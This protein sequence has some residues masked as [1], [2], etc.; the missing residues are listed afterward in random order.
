MNGRATIQDV[1]NLAGVSVATVSR[2]LRGRPNVAQETRARVIEAADRLG[3]EAHT[4]ASSLAS[5][6]TSIVGLVAP[7]FGVWYT[8]QVIAGVERVLSAGGY[9]LLIY[10]VD[11]L[12]SRKRFLD[13]ARI[14]QTRVDGLVL[15]DFFPTKEELERLAASQPKMV[16]I[17][18]HLEPF[19]SY[20][21][22]NVAAAQTAVQHLID[23]GH[24]KVALLG[25]G[26]IPVHE[27]RV[28]RDRRDG[29]L[30]AM[31]AAG[32]P[33]RED[34]VV[35]GLLSVEGGV[36]AM[37][38]MLAMEDRP[39]GLF[40]MSD[41]MAMG[42]IGRARHAGYS[43]PGDLSV[44]GFDDHDLAAAFGLTTMRQPVEELGE[45]AARVLLDSLDGD[46]VDPGNHLLTA[47][48]VVRKTTGP[49]RP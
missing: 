10:T 36:A 19:S 9:D 4:A 41:E 40:C 24:T 37:E 42:V 13:R 18:E 22:D 27:S 5:G 2:A 1:A 32:L 21:I 49:P 45:L 34:L 46:A 48:L 35:P 29:Y 43:V 28:L 25:S 8:G 15:V 26:Q 23:L 47:E 17:G 38:H 11:S 30:V 20:A 44:V 16:V 39:T 3:Y 7:F 14:I 33:P 6:R 31:S 12:E